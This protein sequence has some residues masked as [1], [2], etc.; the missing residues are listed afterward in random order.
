MGNNEKLKVCLCCICAHTR[1][2]IEMRIVKKNDIFF[3]TRVFV[4]RE[5]LA[6]DF[7]HTNEQ[8]VLAKV[9]YSNYKHIYDCHIV[10]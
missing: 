10:I 9:F 5:K 2:Y 7:L 1:A 8:N 3:E 6:R 4:F